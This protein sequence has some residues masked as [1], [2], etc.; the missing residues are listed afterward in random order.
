MYK[1]L[2]EG[3]IDMDIM[4]KEAPEFLRDFCSNLHK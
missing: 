4:I 1:W 2:G 3:Q